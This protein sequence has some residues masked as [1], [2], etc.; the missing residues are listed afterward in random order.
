M[1][2]YDFSQLSA[3]DFEML[4]HSLL[5]KE[6]ACPLEAFKSGRDRGIDLRFC[7][8]RLGSTTIIQCKHYARSTFSKLLSHLT[9]DEAPKVSI[10]TPDRYVLVTSLGL[11]PDNKDAILKAFEPHVKSTGDIIGQTE[12]N[13]LLEKHPEVEQGNFKLWLTS[14][15]VLDRVIHNAE[16]CQAEFVVEKIINKLPF[17]VQNDCYPRAMDILT[18]HNVVVI[19]GEP[20]IGK[21]TL[22]E[23]ILYSHLNNGCAPVVIKSDLRE[24]RALYN[25]T[26]KQIFYYDDFLGQTFLRE[27]HGFLLRNEDTSLVEFVEMIQ[28]S[29]NAKL[30]MT[31]R[32]HI[33]SNALLGSERLRR[34]PLLDHRCILQIMDYGRPARARILYNYI[35]FS[36]LPELYRKLLIEDNFYDEIL[37]HRNFNPRL[38]E[39]LSS[40]RR[41]RDIVPSKYRQFILGILDNPQEIWHEAFQRQISDYARSVLLALFTFGGEAKVDDLRQAWDRLSNFEARKYNYPLSRDGYEAALKE[42]EGS[43]VTIAEGIVEYL[44]PSIKDFISGEISDGPERLSDLVQTSLRVE[45]LVALWRWSRHSKTRGALASVK[46]MSE[47][48]VLAVEASIARP[49]CRVIIFEGG[50]GE[51]RLDLYPE[52]RTAALL[53]MADDLESDRLLALA[54]ALVGSILERWKAAV[55]DFEETTGILGFMENRPWVRARLDGKLYETIREQMLAELAYAS[56]FSDFAH[57]E[58]FFKSTVTQASDSEN[59]AFSIG[60]NAYIESQFSFDLSEIKYNDEDLVEMAS[61]MSK[62]IEEYGYDISTQYERVIEA[63]AERDERAER[64]ADDVY[65]GAKGNP[66]S[67]WANGEAISSMFDSL[68]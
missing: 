53:N 4:V 46:A 18:R 8:P 44:N 20:G 10:L 65:Y 66:G 14:K 13:R 25:K 64:R 22:A 31:T 61:F 40:Y 7:C 23:T 37:R 48:F 63:I 50:T 24:G 57:V 38:I 5:E 9:K 45:Q 54:P 41:I 42:V 47:E 51:Q 49:Y 26:I 39:W 6:W 33:L 2:N 12:I 30:I 55:P 3:F 58:E 15:A 28:A 62:M 36:E 29:Q 16:L 52:A 35:Y 19:S 68:K 1:S 60:F 59:E 32:E 21:T 67:E 27:R 56:S 43:F 17:Y 11:T 34:S